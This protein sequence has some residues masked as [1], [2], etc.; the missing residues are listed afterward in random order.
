MGLG[1]K[2]AIKAVAL[3]LSLL[4]VGVC[5]AQDFDKGLAAYKKK[6]YTLALREWRPLA[7]QGDADAQSNLGL[8]Y[9]TGQ[10]VP[11]NAAEAVKW[12]RLAA[13]QGNASAQYNLGL[14]YAN[15]QGVTQDYVKAYE[16]LS[17]S[18]AQGRDNAKDLRDLAAAELTPQDLSKAQA[19]ATK[20]FESKY[21]NCE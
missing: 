6:D 1:M 18:V 16:W 8:M 21:K 17:L 11:Q 3:G 15:G 2:Y 7:D 4:L 19:I 14:M 9:D 13:D 5:Y 20:C 12:Y 10:G